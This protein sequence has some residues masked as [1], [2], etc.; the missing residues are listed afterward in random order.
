MLLLRPTP[1]VCVDR[2]SILR[3]KIDQAAKRS[4]QSEHF[5]DEHRALQGYLEEHWFPSIKHNQ[6]K[7]FDLHSR[8]LAKVNR[9]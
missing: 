5:A 7:E 9:A 6:R 8:D 4:L 1:G 2:Q 3:L